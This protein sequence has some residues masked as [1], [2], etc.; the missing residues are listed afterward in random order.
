MGHLA[1]DERLANFSIGTHH[2]DP[3]QLCDWNNRLQ[4]LNRTLHRII[5]VCGLD[6][7]NG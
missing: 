5:R 2:V 1:A 3:C 6:H 4:D 7:R